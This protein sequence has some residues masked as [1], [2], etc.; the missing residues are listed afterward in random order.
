MD[1]EYRS[2]CSA[3]TFRRMVRPRTESRSDPD[4]HA[5]RARRW[6]PAI[7]F[8]CSRARPGTGRPSS[9]STSTR[10]EPRTSA[11]TAIAVPSAVNGSVTRTPAPSADSEAKPSSRSVARPV[12]MFHGWMRSGRVAPGVGVGAPAAGVVEG[13]PVAVHEGAGGQQ[14]GLVPAPLRPQRD[15]RLAVDAVPAHAVAAGNQLGVHLPAADVVHLDRR[16]E[17]ALSPVALD[18]PPPLL[19]SGLGQVARDPEHADMGPLVVGGRQAGRL[20]PRRIVVVRHEHRRGR[21][22]PAHEVVALAA[23]RDPHAVAVGARVHHQPVRRCAPGRR[24]RRPRRRP[25]TPGCRDAPASG[26]RR[27]RSRRSGQA[28]SRPPARRRAARPTTRP[29]SGARDRGRPDR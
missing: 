23:G 28:A 10:S 12:S 8:A 29:C 24:E 9:S 2:P 18:D 13:D 17:E 21:Q 14:Q 26:C 22:V 27:R 4:D 25:P 19:P 6:S 16:P 3:Y 7:G 20:R 11:L 5:V 1:S 15:Q